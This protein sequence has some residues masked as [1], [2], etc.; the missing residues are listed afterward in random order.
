VANNVKNQF[1]AVAWRVLSI[2]VHY[3]KQ[4]GRNDWI[5]NVAGTRTDLFSMVYTSLHANSLIASRF[6]FSLTDPRT[7]VCSPISS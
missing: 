3:V 7:C 5:L 2:G 4:G 6:T 1:V